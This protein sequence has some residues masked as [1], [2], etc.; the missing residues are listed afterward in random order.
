M[1]ARLHR[2]LQT[3]GEGVS[4]DSERFIFELCEDLKTS[5]ARGR[6]ISIECHAVSCA[7]SIAQSVPMGLI[8][9]ELVTNALKHAFP[10]AHSG[11][12]LVLLEKVAHDK[13]VLT[14]EDDGVGLRGEAPPYSLGQGLVAVLAQQ[15]GGRVEYNSLGGGSSFCVAFPYANPHSLVPPLHP[16]QAVH[17]IL[18]VR[19]GPIMLWRSSSAAATDQTTNA[20]R[21]NQ[22]RAHPSLLNLPRHLATPGY[23]HPAPAPETS[24]NFVST[25][26][27]Q[28]RNRTAMPQWD[29]RK[30]NLN[31]VPR[32]SDDI[33]LLLD[34][35]RDGWELV[36]ITANNVA[37]LKRRVDEPGP[38]SAP[39]RKTAGSRGPET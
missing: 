6:P 24:P 7:L 3:G 13:L 31:D 39:R 19:A 20:S 29:Y 4:L 9:N 18:P 27:S 26:D 25:L 1:M 30:I 34:A 2:H 11:S 23:F 8:I 15:L 28:E 21:N 38:T 5:M 36:G 14:V 22:Y 10:G 16:Q 33:D 32:K 37:Y 17:W 35:G 12:V